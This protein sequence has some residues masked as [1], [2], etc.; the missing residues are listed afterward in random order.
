MEPEKK[1]GRYQRIYEQ[2]ETLL[3]WES[4]SDTAVN[5]VVQDVI[6]Q[7]RARGDAALID[8]TNRFDGW[9]AKTA[10]DLEIP[11]GDGEPRAHVAELFNRPES[12]G[13]VGRE[14]LL[15]VDQQIAVG[16]MLVPPD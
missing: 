4:V 14:A 6:A 2:L 12:L 10:A 11:H 9:E 16:P 1:R 3:A 7:I 5:D 8:F 15:R 13:R